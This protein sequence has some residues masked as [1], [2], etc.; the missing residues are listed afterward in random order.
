M[1]PQPTGA[2]GVM[3]TL[4]ALERLALASQSTTEMATHLRVDPRSARKLLQRL[5]LEGY[6]VQEDGHRKRYR[7]TLRLAAMGR[8]LLERAA[9]PRAAERW[10]AE[11][12]A[13]TSSSAH[14]WIPAADGVMC[15]IHG[16][17][18]DEPGTMAVLDRD[19][20]SQ[21]SCVAGP[22]VAA[23]AVLERG[24]V[25]AAIGVTGDVAADDL[26]AVVR[27]ARALSDELDAAG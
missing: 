17:A 10:L 18:P 3:N 1:P 16:G 23:A 13:T 8:Q 2:Y 21:R 25:V 27:V 14:L 20:M 4:R 22:R 6:V 9:L 24:T 7:A 12:A 26:G 15:L 11:L 5:A 19:R